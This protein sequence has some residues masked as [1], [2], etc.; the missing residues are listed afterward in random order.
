MT[1][2]GLTAP[3]LISWLPF[4][5][6]TILGGLASGFVK[7]DDID[8]RLR[9][10]FISKPFIGMVSGMAVTTYLNKNV[11]PPPSD[12]LFWAFVVSLCATPI[13]CGFLVFIS[14]QNRQNEFY[15]QAKERILPNKHK[16]DEL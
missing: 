11:E 15:I 10:P 6:F 12:L 7:I 5:V 13:V 1:I 4:W 2:T 3:F 9:Y 14:D 16:G 8:N